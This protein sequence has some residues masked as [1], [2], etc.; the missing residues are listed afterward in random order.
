MSDE[1]AIFKIT[2]RGYYVVIWFMQGKN[3][4]MQAMLYREAEGEPFQLKF[5]IRH[6]VDDKAI[7]SDDV[8]IPYE[9]DVPPEAER[10]E[11]KA[12]ELIEALLIQPLEQGGFLSEGSATQRLWIRG[13]WKAWLEGMQSVPWAHIHVPSA[14]A[15]A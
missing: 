11:H 2:E 6:Y 3:E 12:I 4:D 13:D 14:K 10:D 7:G 1:G 5:R 8:K 15:Q 9:W